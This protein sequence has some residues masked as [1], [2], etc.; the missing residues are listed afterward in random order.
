[1][2]EIINTYPEKSVS[3]TADVRISAARAIYKELLKV[4]EEKNDEALISCCE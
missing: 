3:D 2:Y 4:L 1:M